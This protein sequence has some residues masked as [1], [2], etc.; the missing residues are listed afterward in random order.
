M[1]IKEIARFLHDNKVGIL[2]EVGKAGDIFYS[3]LPNSPDNCISIFQN[4]GLEPDPFNEYKT[5]AIQII[6]R[7]VNPLEGI[8]RGQRIINMLNGFNDSSFVSGGLYIVDSDAQQ[9]APQP[10][11]QDKNGRYEYSFNFL[12]EYKEG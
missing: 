9:S 1:L 10:I 5:P 4:S 8:E 11:G 2:D 6:V 12:I 3:R 7:S